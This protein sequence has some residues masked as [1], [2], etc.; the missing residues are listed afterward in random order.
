MRGRAPAV[1]H[2]VGDEQ[3]DG[4]RGWVPTEPPCDR[5]GEPFLR[6]ELRKE[7]SELEQLG[8]DLDDE[9]RPRRGVPA[10]Q[11]DHATLAEL[12]V[13]D[14]GSDDP[15]IERVD[16]AG[17]VVCE[18]GVPAV[19]DPIEINRASS[20]LQQNPDPER[21]SNR[22]NRFDRK[23]AEVAAFEPRHGGDRYASSAGEVCLPPPALDPGETDKSTERDVVHAA[24][25]GECRLSADC[26]TARAFDMLAPRQ[27]REPA[28][29]T[30]KP[31]RGQLGSGRGRPTGERG[32]QAYE[33]GCGAG[34]R[35][36]PEAAIPQHLAIGRA[37]RPLYLVFWAL[38]ARVESRYRTPLAHHCQEPRIDRSDTPIQRPA[39]RRNRAGSDDA[40][41]HPRSY[42]GAR[43]HR[44]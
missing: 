43:A 12:R 4:R 42:A 33:R 39:T 28:R 9:Q 30:T 35:G 21:S 34:E 20:S 16:P 36:R 41:Q 27:A 13:R 3:A 19:R 17:Q 23:L 5:A 7:L 8:L 32:K 22:P 11:V 2:R 44:A 26:E 29:W 25:V 10:Q 31:T 6:I 38:T 1:R 14:L 18:A 37:S 40:T 24:D 15:A